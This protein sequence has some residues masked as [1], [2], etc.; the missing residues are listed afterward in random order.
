MS[1]APIH[2]T[3]QA[4]ARVLSSMKDIAVLP[5]VVFKIMEMTGNTDASMLE[6]EKAIVID[7][8]FSTKLLTIANSA[9]FGLPKK[10]T[11]I[12]EAAMFV[13]FKQIRQMA[14]AVGLFDMF[15]GKTDKESLRRRDWWRHSLDSAVCSQ[16]IAYRFGVDADI[17]Y[18]CGLLHYIGKT[19]LCR[20]DALAY[21]KV[22]LVVERGASVRQAEVAVFGCDHQDVAIAA[23]IKWG[24]PMTLISGL[25]YM[26]PMGPQ[27]PEPHLRAATALG[28]SFATLAITGK[29][30]DVGVAELVPGWASALLKIGSDEL[31][32]LMEE[33]AGAIAKAVKFGL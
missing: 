20:S 18:T 10:V 12:R 11:S 31:E 29:P 4:V 3:E 13:G 9:S 23:G 17:A 25:V 33:C 5:Q 22:E 19:L 30:H 8:G 24:F 21:T 32:N 2:N 14:M 1:A 7:P 15:V 16:R 28:D 26:D 27:D 6:L